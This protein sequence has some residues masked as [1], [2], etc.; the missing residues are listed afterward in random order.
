MSN[1]VR[2]Y[3]G[4]R[5][6]IKIYENSSHNAEWTPSTSYERLTLVTYNYSTYLSKDNVPATV[7]NPADNPDYWVETGFYNGQISSLQSQID[8]IMNDIIPTIEADL[9][10]VADIMNPDHYILVIGDSYMGGNT[11]PSDEICN[12]FK[13]TEDENLFLYARGGLGFS[14]MSNARTENYIKDVVLPALTSDQ[15][16]KIKTVLI[17]TGAND[18]QL[19]ASGA[20]YRADIDDGIHDAINYLKA[21][22]PNAMIYVADIAAGFT[23]SKEKKLIV[24]ECY[25]NQVVSNGAYYLGNIGNCLKVGTNYI[26]VNVDGIHPTDAGALWLGKH[27]AQALAHAST[28]VF[29]NY[30]PVQSDC[31][32]RIDANILKY[33]WNAFHYFAPSATV[34]YESNVTCNGSNKCC[35]ITDTG[36]SV[37]GQHDLI[38]VATFTGSCRNES[39]VFYVAPIIA[40]FYGDGV[41]EL[42]PVIISANAFVTDTFTLS[43]TPFEIDIPIDE[44]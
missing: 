11:H 6:T 5:Y 39:N 19:A 21:G 38:G 10:S 23:Y 25:A 13:K 20:T 1:N 18:E 22:L 32:C 3:I 35:T 12:F 24:Q 9:V 27:L 2:Q 8:H 30:T 33:K 26:Y 34:V 7:G 15:K 4:A 17:A 40:K 14:A 42:Y 37:T 29:W 41:L 31:E 36:V 43:C 16:N 44:Y 28:D